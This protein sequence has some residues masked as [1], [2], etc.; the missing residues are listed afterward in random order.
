[1]IDEAVSAR[2]IWRQIARRRDQVCVE[3]MHRRYRYGVNYYSVT[4]LPDCNAVGEAG[5]R[6]AERHRSAATQRPRRQVTWRRR[7]SSQSFK[8]TIEANSPT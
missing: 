6:R 4:P 8:S 5:A 3:W 1:M 2:P 7:F